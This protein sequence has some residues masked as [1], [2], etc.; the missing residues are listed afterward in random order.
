MDSVITSNT[1]IFFD[2][3]GTLVDT[4]TANFL[5]YKAAI[6]E[7]VNI[8]IEDIYEERINRT[9]LKKI[10]TNTSEELISEIVL[11]KEKKYSEY[12]SYTNL[13]N[14]NHSQLV[15]YSNT[16]KI[17]LVTN[18]RKG[19]AIQLLEY[20]QITNYFTDFIFREEVNLN[21]YINKYSLA[22]QKLDINKNHVLIFE[23]EI[24]EINKALK[25]GINKNQIIKT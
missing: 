1:V 8:K 21:N 19:R 10:L 6:F 17:Y 22:I 3:D 13:I 18:C 4:D 25:I 5:A 11:H 2:L 20:H 16:N 9:L 24:I 23:N 12:L 7:I 15:K 14:K